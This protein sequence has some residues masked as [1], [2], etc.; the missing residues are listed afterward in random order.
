MMQCNLH[1]PMCVVVVLCLYI[2][3]NTNNKYTIHIFFKDTVSD[4][5]QGAIHIHASIP[6]LK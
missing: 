1:L 5:Y 4:N 3:Y 2:H 6:M